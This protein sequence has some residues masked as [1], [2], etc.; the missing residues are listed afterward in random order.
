MT[1]ATSLYPGS[2]TVADLL[3][4]L[5]DISPRRVLARPFP[6]TATEQDVIDLETREK[7]LCELVDG[8][9]VEK[10]MGY[11]ESMLAAQLITFLGEFLKHHD[12]GM[13][14][15]AD[16]ALRL[17]PGLVRIPDVSF[18]SWN[19]LP[20][21]QVPREPIPDLVPDLAGEVLSE[22]NT[23]REMERKLSEYFQ[24]GVRLV[25]FIEPASRS[26][27][28]YTRSIF[29]RGSARTNLSRV[30]TCFAASRCPL[31][32]SSNGPPRSRTGEQH[33]ANRRCVGR[34]A[35]LG[36]W[37]RRDCVRRW[38]QA[39]RSVGPMLCWD[40]QLEPAGSAFKAGRP[41][42]CLQRVLSLCRLPRAPRCPRG[43]F[44]SWHT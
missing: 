5:G 2:R 38:P 36:K 33:A 13:L 7:R 24:A 3:E 15:G 34:R 12:L 11:F 27:R 23:K 44:L 22:G 39:G 19:R 21:R 28:V 8:V 30:A 29:A 14:A 4:Q 6:G 31:S 35:H 42:S 10:T 41:S 17:W 26:A 25:W 16:G 1:L 9:L 40:R 32:N 37:V 20:N 43:L 18:V